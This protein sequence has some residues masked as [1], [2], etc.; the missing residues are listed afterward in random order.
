MNTTIFIDG[1]CSREGAMRVALVHNRYH[2]VKNVGKLGT[3][4]IAEYKALLYALSY[5]HRKKLKNVFI[6]SDFLSLVQQCNRKCKVRS[7]SIR[8]YFEK[9]SQMIEQCPT[10]NILHVQRN[11]N[12]A[13]KLF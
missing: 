2:I 10:I 1:S 3:S 5:I 11:N 8:C 6:L 7:P 4:N 9:A 13:G 12:L